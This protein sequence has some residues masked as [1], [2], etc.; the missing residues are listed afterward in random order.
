MYD[1]GSIVLRRS[2]LSRFREK[3]ST[4]SFCR[5]TRNVVFPAL[6]DGLYSFSTIA[7]GCSD[8]KGFCA[9][10][11]F[12]LSFQNAVTPAVDG[13]RQSNGA[14]VYS[15]FAEPDSSPTCSPSTFSVY[16]EKDGKSPLRGSPGAQLSA[17]DINFSGCH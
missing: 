4:A 6:N 14:P 9:S 13:Y 10:Y 2:A 3:R 1:H 17:Q 12:L 5:T 8:Q 15:V 16:F 7:N 11:N